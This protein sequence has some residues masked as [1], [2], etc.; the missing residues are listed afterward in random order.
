MVSAWVVAALCR[1]AMAHP[2]SMTCD[3]TCL[4]QYTPGSPFGLM[5]VSNVGATSG[6]TCK[7]T[8]DIPRMAIPQ[9][10]LT[11]VS[12]ESDRQ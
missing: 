2:S 10:L 5:Y 6:N 7:I 12:A 11:L 1:A 3:Y 4:A 9:I 8:T